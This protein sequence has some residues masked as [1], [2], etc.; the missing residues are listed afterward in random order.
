MNH[1]NTLIE[2]KKIIENRNFDISDPH[3]KLDFLPQEEA[4]VFLSSFPLF[5]NILFKFDILKLTFD[6]E[7]IKKWALIY[8]ALHNLFHEKYNKIYGSDLTKLEIYSTAPLFLD[9]KDLLEV[10]FQK[11]TYAYFLLGSSSLK[12]NHSLP[13]LISEKLILGEFI[14]LG[15]LEESLWGYQLKT[16]SMPEVAKNILEKTEK[17]RIHHL[18]KKY[19][20]FIPNFL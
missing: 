7:E 10:D 8:L 13:Y 11:L 20:N 17:D 5:D 19:Q 4:K 9:T 3:F 2:L 16:N 14:A 1:S 18:I 6:K 15:N 12:T